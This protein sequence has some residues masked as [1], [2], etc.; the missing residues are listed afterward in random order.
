MPN[1]IDRTSIG[2]SDVVLDIG[3]GS[4]TI[5]EELLKKC[6]KVIA[7]E[8]DNNL[9]DKLNQRFGDRQ[10][11]ELREG[12]FLSFSLPTHPYKV[13]SNIPFNITSTIIKNLTL[14]NNPPQD[15][16]LIIQKE[17]AAKFAGKPISTTNSLMS[18]LLNPW[19]EFHIRHEFQ[20]SDFYPKPSVDVVLFEIKQRD[21]ELVDR[22]NK[23]QY[24]DFIT[25]SFS[26]FEPNITETL[27]KVFGKQTTVQLTEKLKFSPKS[28]PSELSFGNWV[29]LFYE[30]LKT[31][32][33]QQA[34]VKSSFGKLLKQQEKIDK[35]HR[36]RKDPDWKSKK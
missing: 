23:S 6:K 26:Q 17:A 19:F 14:S 32:H 13:F 11:F 5:T 28:K 22:K 29:G 35:I 15:C 3:A 12:N 2:K 30:F 27:T 16:Y 9:A 8:L 18:V 10:N 34:I 4:G 21:K 7:F 24:E 25:Y 31:S 20:R 36:T 1:L 33:K